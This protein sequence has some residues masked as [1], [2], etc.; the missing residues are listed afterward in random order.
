MSI[1]SGFY[2]GTNCSFIENSQIRV[3][4][5]PQIGGKI[6]SL[7]YKPQNFEVLFQPTEGM[8]FLPQYGG[9]FA[10]FDTSGADEMFPT[11]DSCLYPYKEYPG[12]KCPDH[13][14]LWSI[15]WTVTTEGD[16]L[17]SKVKGVAF[18][19]LFVRTIDLEDNVIHLRYQVTNLG[20]K[21]FYGL[22]AF[23]GLIACDPWTRL[24]L[25]ETEK[26]IN[27]HDSKTLGKA[28]TRHNFP[29]T[30]DQDGNEYNLSTIFPKS[31]GKTEKF[32]LEGSVSKGEAALSLN[33]GQLLYKLIFP[34][35]KVPYLGVWINEGGFKGE[36]NCAL[37]PSTG[38]YDSLEITH[39]LDTLESINPGGTF[40]WFLDIYLESNNGEGRVKR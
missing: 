37:E 22:W 26:V 3:T 7:I 4:V 39:G 30:L 15:P 34:R 16:S 2:K 23:H 14:E 28:D 21:P 13:G 19:Y 29:I 1:K 38:Y 20:E 33:S 35:E 9:D 27:V 32:Y 18:P 17:I 8:Y 10:S 24:I 25:P 6:A 40:D 31:R 36:Y 5:L 12:V 11:I